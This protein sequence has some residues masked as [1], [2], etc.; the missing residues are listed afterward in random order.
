ML[1][2][3]SWVDFIFFIFLIY[4]ALTSRGFIESIVDIFDF[5]IS[6]F[7]A[8]NF[9]KDIG[10]LLVTYFSLSSGIANAAGFFIAWSI[11]ETILHIPFSYILSLP[12]FKQLRGHELN[13]YLGYLSGMAQGVLFFFFFISMIFALP[14]RGQLKNDILNSQTGP[15]FVAASQK[16]EQY[17]KQVFG[18]FVSETINFMT[19]KPQ[20]SERVQL[21]FKAAETT[22]VIDSKSEAEMLQLVNKERTERGLSALEADPELQEV[23]RSYAKTMLVHGFFSHVS[24]VDGSSPAERAEAFGVEYMVLGENLA[25][26]PDVYIAHQGLMNSEGHR[27]NILSADYG[28]VGIGVID[29]GIYG[30][31]FVQMFRN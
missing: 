22:L 9:Y 29:A 14:V 25:Y 18:G 31:M 11:T 23:A 3:F 12:L 13:R 20:S 19:I 6:L 7:L 10:A 30:R 8:Y 2:A 24:Q 4:F 26:A 1:E 27:K 21:D 5:F 15:I 16:T 28:R 17:I